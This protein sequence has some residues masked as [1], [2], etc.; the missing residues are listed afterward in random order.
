MTDQRFHILDAMRG[1]AAIAVVLLHLAQHTKTPQPPFAYLAVDFFFMLSGF[2]LTQAYEPMI[3]SGAP[4]GRFLKS[5]IVRLCP[6]FAI[7]VIL[8]TLAFANLIWNNDP[9]APHAK[10][11]VLAAV[12]NVFL[13]PD[14]ISLSLFP[15]NP[16]GWSLFLEVAVN[17]LFAAILCGLSTGKLAAI[18]ALTAATLSYYVVQRETASFG[19]QWS[20]ISLGILRTIYG[21]AFGML[22]ARLLDSL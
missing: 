4:I 15:T 14:P 16:P 6:I 5:R 3:R 11:L 19:T 13:L 17:I 12:L 18:C 20:D 21:F 7:G 10:G 22:V 9:E 2:V 1:V 8:G